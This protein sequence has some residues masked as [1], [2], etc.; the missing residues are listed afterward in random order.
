MS[1]RALFAHTQPMISISVAR[2]GRGKEE[3]EEEENRP[4]HC[5]AATET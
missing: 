3:E 5:G 2:Q 1:N 4:T